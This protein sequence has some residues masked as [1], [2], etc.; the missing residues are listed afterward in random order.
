MDLVVDGRIKLKLI[1]RKWDG[2]I[3]WVY[4]FQNMDGR[5]ALVNAVTNLRVK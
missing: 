2:G 5:R 4:L 3:G 1:F